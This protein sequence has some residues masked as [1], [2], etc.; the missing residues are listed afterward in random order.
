[1]KQLEEAYDEF[2]TQFST[3]QGYFIVT[4]DTDKVKVDELNTTAKYIKSS[5][6][7]CMS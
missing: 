1:V 4:T 2:Q 7:V 3:F 6:K 5:T